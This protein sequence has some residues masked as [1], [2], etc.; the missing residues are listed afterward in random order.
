MN[1]QTIQIQKAI[2]K[3]RNPYPDDKLISSYKD[4]LKFREFLPNY[5]F[6][7]RV[8]HSLLKVTNET[9]HSRKRIGRMS[10]VDTL[11]RYLKNNKNSVL[12]LESRQLIF[13]IFRKSIEEPEPVTQNHVRRIRA[14]LNSLLKNQP[15]TEKEEH[16][17]CSHADLSEHIFNRILRYPVRSKV[18]HDWASENYNTDRYRLRRAEM[19]GWIISEKPD[20]EIDRQTLID[21][22]SYVNMLDRKQIQGYDD[23]AESIE[24]A[25]LS[26]HAYF[27][28]SKNDL[29]NDVFLYEAEL[30]S[31]AA[32]IKFQRRP[33]PVP[34]IPGKQMESYPVKD[35][36]NESDSTG[37]PFSIPDFDLLEKEFYDN[38]EVFFRSTMVWSIYYSR[39]EKQQKVER[40]KKYYH[41]DTF[42]S[43]LKICSRMEA[44]ELLKWMKKNR[45]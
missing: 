13:E 21:D 9:W 34:M 19:A 29:I 36:G 8:F 7:P 43:F 39:L 18:I 20:F 14:M 33:Y 22:F 3:I 2:D 30:E 40:L 25:T 16:W 6:N 27:P 12:E 10:L 44:V 35:H 26:K 17:L 45:I 31:I 1:Q 28:T 41:E 4:F 5:R 23:E 37:Y 32:E 38:L 15:L 11:R 24:F 42:R